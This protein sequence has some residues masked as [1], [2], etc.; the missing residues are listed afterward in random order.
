MQQDT[1]HN[2]LSEAVDSELKENTSDEATVSYRFNQALRLAM[3]VQ[4]NPIF[5]GQL[6]QF[7]M[8]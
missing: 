6:S 5:G 8:L 2:H 3:V 4:P 7:E 1:D